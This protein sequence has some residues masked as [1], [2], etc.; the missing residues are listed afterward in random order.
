M[1][2]WS[3]EFFCLQLQ[4][5][6]NPLLPLK[7][8]ILSLTLFMLIYST[9]FSRSETPQDLSLAFLR[10]SE[11]GA[12]YFPWTQAISK[13][14]DLLLQQASL[15]RKPPSSLTVGQESSLVPLAFPLSTHPHEHHQDTS[16]APPEKPWLVSTAVPSHA[17]SPGDFS[18]PNYSHRHF[19]FCSITP[20]LPPAVNYS[21]LGEC[22]QDLWLY[23]PLSTWCRI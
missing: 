14:A 7:P 5:N 19:I 22:C 21:S 11:R 13:W 12:F 6:E 1:N 4:D 9:A 3:N 23:K 16:R 18:S 10:V 2:F 8:S 17:P 20:F 15:F